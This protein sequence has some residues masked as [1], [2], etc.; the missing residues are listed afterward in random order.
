[1]LTTLYLASKS[2]IPEITT[3]IQFNFYD[4]SC[5]RQVLPVEAITTMDVARHK[6][7]LKKMVLIPLE[8]LSVHCF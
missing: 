7:M 8:S 2:F 5:L 1:M 4:N 6:V 3:E